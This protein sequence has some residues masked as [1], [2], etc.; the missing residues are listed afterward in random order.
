MF[1]FQP[2]DRE[3]F[4]RNRHVEVRAASSSKA[5]RMASIST[6][7]ARYWMAPSLT[8]STAVAMLA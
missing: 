3:G 7:L 4:I 5:V 8:A 6:G 2:V 1:P